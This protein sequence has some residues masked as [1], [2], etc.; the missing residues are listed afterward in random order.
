VN[1]R[2]RVVV[3][4]PVR[5][6]VLTRIG[7]VDPRISVSHLPELAGHGLERAALKQL[8]PELRRA[9]VLFG[10][11]SMPRECL[12]AAENLKWLQVINA[13]VDC[14]AR[15]G[16]LE[17]GFV[18]TNMSGLVA[19]AIAEYVIGAILMLSKGFHLA[20]RHQE[21][22]HWGAWHVTELTGQTVGIV[23]LGAI[24]R[25][26]ARRARAM[27]MRVIASR[28]TAPEG[29]TDDDC[30]EL[31]SHRSLDRLLDESDYVVL[32]VPLTAETHHLIGES[33]L[34][35]MKPAATLINIARGSVVHQEALMRAL[36]AG[37]IGAAV[38]DVT[39][40]EP[41]PETSPIW[42]LPNVIVTPHISGS[43][44][45]YGGRSAELF[46]ANLQR[47]L[48]GETLENVV[49]P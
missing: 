44:G 17:R 36:R 10:P 8:L 35:R 4:F 39:D 16:L 25:E 22:H 37:A 7:A 20:I 34:A 49:N 45:G 12:E 13:G 15:D 43:I 40:P 38:F 21:E 5:E 28:R 14:L 27:G 42:D 3:G 9:D 2:L 33:E 19:V 18:V 48:R 11:A 41:L 6:G 30:D 46:V 32:C 26:T 47:Y 29:S 23:G 24:G 31:L 1:E